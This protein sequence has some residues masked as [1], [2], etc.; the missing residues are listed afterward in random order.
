MLE[1]DGFNQQKSR[2]AIWQEKKGY[3][4]SASTR[5]CSVF[6]AVVV[7]EE[8]NVV[9]QSEGESDNDR[10]LT[11]KKRNKTD[12]EKRAAEAIG[13]IVDLPLFA[14]QFGG[15][16]ELPKTLPELTSTM[17]DFTVQEVR[18][19]LS[20]AGEEDISPELDQLSEVDQKAVKV[21]VNHYNYFPLKAIGLV[22]SLRAIADS[23]G[24]SKEHPLDSKW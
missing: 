15:V 18:D 4:M 8:G 14:D 23:V 20:I 19:L 13:S 17:F 6:E 2:H 12:K 9:V 10:D 24:V 21:L 16:D 11:T 1:F 3:Q 5:S 7:D 22:R